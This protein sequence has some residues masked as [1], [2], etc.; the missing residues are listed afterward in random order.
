MEKKGAHVSTF[1]KWCFNGMSVS[2]Y[3]LVDLH[4]NS[5]YPKDDAPLP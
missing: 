1:K 2:K 4:N 5:K 3:K